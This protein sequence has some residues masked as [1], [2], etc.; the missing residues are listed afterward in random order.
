MYQLEFDQGGWIIPFFANVENATNTKVAGWPKHDY[1]G[2][3][4]GNGHFE[5]VYLT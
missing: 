3:T 2:R 4:F 5:Q 1:S